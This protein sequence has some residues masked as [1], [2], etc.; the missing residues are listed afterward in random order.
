MFVDGRRGR[1]R[2]SGSRAVGT[3]EDVLNL[4]NCF[5]VAAMVPREN[6]ASMCRDALAVF[7]VLLVL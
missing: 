2:S 5:P 7:Q 1:A 3:C 6:L 4:M